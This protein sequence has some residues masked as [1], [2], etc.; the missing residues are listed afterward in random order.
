M[1]EG[2]VAPRTSVLPSASM[3]L[4]DA[5]EQWDPL[6]DRPA[7]PATDDQVAGARQAVGWR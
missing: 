6:V 1:T 4:A 7:L 3:C 2:N 5:P